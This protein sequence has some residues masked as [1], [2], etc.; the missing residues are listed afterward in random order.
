MKRIG[1]MGE[2]FGR[3]VNAS[4][5]CLIAL[6]ASAAICSSAL[7][8]QDY[9]NRPVRMIVPYAAGG[10]TD[11]FARSLAESWGRKLGNT[12]IVENKTGAGTLVGTELAAKA[13]PDGYTVLLTTVAHAVNPSIHERLP[14]RTIEDFLPIGLAAKAPLVLVVNKSLPVNTLAQ[15]IDYLKTHPGK[16]NYGSAGVGSAPH[17]AGELLNYMAGTK[18][19]HVPYR[20][21]APAMADVIGGHLDFMIDSAPTG[22]AQV[23]AGTVKLLA[24]S[25]AQRLPQ[26]PDTPAMGEQIKGY[27]AYTWNAVFVPAGTPPEVAAKLTSSLREALQD[28]ALKRRAYDMGLII[29]PNPDPKA[30]SAFLDSELEKWSK[31]AKAANMSAN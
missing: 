22:L 25:M 19:I 30:L 9:P 15:F 24:T 27:D 29:E 3:V 1:L 16:V 2:Q 7:A 17:L 26:T 13:N 21:S 12:L 28:E 5:G 6:C 23:Q 31:V 4:A 20:G 11:T 18:A 10:P 8:A 14:Y